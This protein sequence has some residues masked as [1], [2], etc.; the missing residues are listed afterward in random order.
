MRTVPKI[1]TPVTLVNRRRGAACLAIAC[2]AGLLVTSH[3]AAQSAAQSPTDARTTP[4]TRHS[5]PGK[6]KNAKTDS[7]PAAARAAVKSKLPPD[8]RLYLDAGYAD[9]LLRG[10]QSKFRQ[11]ATPPAGF[12]LRDLRYAP[13]Y[14]APSESGFLELKGIGQEDYLVVARQSWDY[15]A[16]QASG[17]L[18]RASFFDPT[19][20]PF[21]SSWRRVNG[22]NLHRL[23]NRDFAL[24]FN[25]R[26][27]EELLNYVI[28]FPALDQ[29]IE[30]WDGNATGKLGPGA[31]RLYVS[32][33]HFEDHSGTYTNFNAQTLGARYL[34]NVSRTVGIAAEATHVK[35]TQ[36]D[37][38]QSHVD[39]LSLAG[40]VEFGPTTDFDVLFLRRQLTLPAVQNAYERTQ[41]VGAFG[42]SQRWQSWRAQIGLRLQNADRVNG[43]QDYVDVPKWS[44]FD[45]RLSGR[46]TRHLKL[47]VQG[48]TQSL[49]N[50]PPSTLNDPRSL[51]WTNR[52]FL[53][54]RLESGT[55]D[56]NGY[57]TFTALNQRN[58]ARSTTVTTN[59]YTLGGTWEIRPALNLFAEFHHEAWSGHTDTADNLALRSFLPD[60]NT[61][62]VELNWNPNARSYISVNY[63]G[64]AT[65]NDNP[66]LL[67]D[68]NTHGNFVTLSGRYRFPAGYEMSLLVAPW[69]YRDSVVNALDYSATI[70]MLTGSVRF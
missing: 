36:P 69:T 70:V 8:S 61:A 51:Y 46:I 65:F 45:G 31:A 67:Q 66:L 3:G 10:N 18:S 53:Q 25:Y 60:S 15:G 16:T 58:G 43:T 68:G 50:A 22:F 55:P 40:N 48:Y 17:F 26:A 34:W 39:T 19:P 13:N 47:T 63:T 64:F 21:D 30:F 35:I 4:D 28:P 1:A 5:A 56:L 29:K 42:L 27:D 38:P 7:P 49:R 52:S 37:L 23:L 9:W 2:L 24:N 12:F 62:V 57:L 14:R 33:L 41:N 6:G 44:T 11:Y 32:N 59:Q 54:A 20:S